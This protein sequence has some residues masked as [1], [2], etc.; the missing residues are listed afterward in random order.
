MVRTGDGRCGGFFY[1]KT[2]SCGGCLWLLCGQGLSGLANLWTVGEGE[3]VVCIGNNVSE[4]DF[5]YVSLKER[6][7]SCRVLSYDDYVCQQN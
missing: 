5:S 7:R 3:K 2:G 6:I 1:S 4:K